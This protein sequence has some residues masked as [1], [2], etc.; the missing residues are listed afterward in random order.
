VYAFYAQRGETANR[1]EER[2]LAL[3]ADRTSCHRFLGNA[4]RVILYTAAFVLWVALR[5]CP[6]G[7]ELAQARVFSLRARLARV[8]G[9]VTQ[10]ARRVL[11]R[12]P[13][14]YPWPNLWFRILERL[15]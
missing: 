15:A 3:E 12:C 6:E 13:Q 7:T 14:A 9:F 10:S 1:V 11:I 2:K 4:F 8:A 5:A